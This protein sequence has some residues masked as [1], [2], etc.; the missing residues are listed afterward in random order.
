MMEYPWTTAEKFNKDEGRIGGREP[1]LGL[2]M[3]GGSC[4]HHNGFRTSDRLSQG[5]LRP[6]HA[7]IIK[8]IET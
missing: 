1:T 3:E 6:P 8:C 7:L 4:G 5:G 2:R